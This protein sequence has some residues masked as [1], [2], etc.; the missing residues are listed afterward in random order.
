MDLDCAIKFMTRKIA[1]LLENNGPSVYLYGSCVLDDFCDGWSDIDIL[2][3]T[4]K[5]MTDRQARE[6]VG[7]RQVLSDEYSESVFRSFEGGILTLEAFI[8]HTPDTVVYWGTSGQRI[9]D[10]YDFDACCMKE[11]FDFGCLM[12]GKDVRDS[13]TP[14]SFE[15]LRSNVAAHY[16]SIRKYAH[17]SGRSIYSFGWLLDISRCIHTLRTGKII[18]KTASG[19]WALEKGIFPDPA[20]LE[21]ALKIRHE[22]RVFRESPGLQAVAENLGGDIQRYADVL[23]NE[24]KRSGC[25]AV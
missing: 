14:P 3:L 20:P 19:E 17:L 15:D 21:L 1:D 4:E 22:P 10:S 12:Y 8:S 13:L 18:S 11:L 9:A 16:D 7:L 6:L 5:R 23:E 2:V 24:L 25:E